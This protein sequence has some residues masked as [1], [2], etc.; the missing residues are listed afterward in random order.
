MSLITIN[1]NRFV[2]VDQIR[3][4]AIIGVII[5]HVSAPM[6]YKFGQIPLQWW[7]V[8]NMFNSAVRSSVP[9]FLM[10]SG[11][12]LIPK[13]LAP[14]TFI[15][16]RFLRIVYPFLFWAGIHVIMDLILKIQLNKVHTM[17]DVINSISDTAEMGFAFHYWY[18]YAIVGIYL[19]L[20]I[21]GKWARNSTQKEINYFLIIWIICILLGETSISTFKYFNHLT[22]FFSGSIGFVILGYYIHR[23]QLARNDMKF[24]ILLISLI[25]VSIIVTSVGTYILTDRSG[26][27]D[28]QLYSIFSPFNMIVAVCLFLLIRNFSI[29]NTILYILISFISKYSYGIY[30][31]HIVVLTILSSY[32]IDGMFLHP[33]AG[34]LITTVLCLGF[35]GLIVFVINKLPFGKYIS[36]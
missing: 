17:Q 32:K 25:V 10:I 34:I 14:L 23:F 24:F 4:T 16:K 1:K 29:Q 31:S 6:I 36:G 15:K 8:A 20:P 12:L 9:L 21:I 3:A 7:L 26:K 13:E 5:L 27:S 30:L 33:F 35:S 28:L 11:V 22:Y 18:V 19:F 2:W